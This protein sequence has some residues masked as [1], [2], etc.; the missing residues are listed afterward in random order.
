MFLRH[1]I[2][3]EGGGVYIVDFRSRRV[4]EAKVS[5]VLTHEVPS[6]PHH[7]EQ[8]L[9]RMVGPILALVAFCFNLFLSSSSIS[10]KNEVTKILGPFDASK[11]PESQKH[12]EKKSAS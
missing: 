3:L 9:G 4:H 7:T 10:Q 11:V 5:D 12:E 6:G 2:A 8:V 1:P